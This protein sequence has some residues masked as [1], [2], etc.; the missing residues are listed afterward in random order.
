M[1]QFATKPWRPY[2]DQYKEGKISVG[3]FNTTVFSLVT[4]DRQTMVDFVQK[5][6]RIRPGL[7]RLLEFCRKKQIEFVIT[8][9]GLDFYISFILDGLGMNGTR[10][11]AARTQF[12]PRGLKV[13][14]IGPDGKELMDKFKETYT[15]LFLSEGYRVIYIGNGVSDFPSARLSYR[16]FACQDL[17]ESCKEGK[18]KCIPFDDMNDVVT[19]LRD[20]E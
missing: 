16:V 2:W 15:R 12:D 9:N 17:L 20:L 3:Q 4:A 11:I 14:Y 5:N 13:Q 10:V 7:A 1:D 19:G 8:S 6:A 18:L